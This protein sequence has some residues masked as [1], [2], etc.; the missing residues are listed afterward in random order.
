MIRLTSNK[1]Q[2]KNKIPLYLKNY[3]NKKL[4][5]IQHWRD[6]VNNS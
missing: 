1:I 6:T 4:Y 2:I 3:Q 5:K